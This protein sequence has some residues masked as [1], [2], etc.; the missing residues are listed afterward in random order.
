MS[1]FLLLST[2]SEICSCNINFS[3]ESRKKFNAEKCKYYLFGT[4]FDEKGAERGAK[5]AIT[6]ECIS[7]WPSVRCRQGLL[8]PR[9][10]CPDRYSAL[11][12]L[13][14]S[15]RTFTFRPDFA[16]GLSPFL[17]WQRRGK[18]SSTCS[19]ILTACYTYLVFADNS[20]NNSREIRFFG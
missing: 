12:A 2:T 6:Y 19:L 20:R 14:T 1:Q 7:K 18:C 4:H 15:R 5:G 11:P 13:Y 9:G 8:R 16:A 10:G 17:R 3:I